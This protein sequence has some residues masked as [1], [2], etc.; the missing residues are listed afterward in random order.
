MELQKKSYNSIIEN[1]LKQ[2]ENI[3]KTEKEIK[4]LKEAY[5]FIEKLWNIQYDKIEKIKFV[6][7]SE[8]PLFGD[9]KHYFYNSNSKFKSFFHK[10]NMESF[11][12]ENYDILDKKEIIQKLNEK[13]F[14]I[15]DLFMFPLNG[16]NTS[17]N[18]RKMKKNRRKELF[19]ISLEFYLKDKLEKI[20]RK[21]SDKIKFFYRYKR[22][23]KII[24]IDF[25]KVLKKKELISRN[26]EIETISNGNMG[27]DNEKL[28][29]IV[30]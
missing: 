25:E 6:M 1:C 7:I 30:S 21:K 5:N 22:L 14:I 20:E 13:G 11:G 24:G 16:K 8:A 17:E 27:I 23:K 19:M 2:L 4:Y 26:T 10:S 28:K 18:F 12:I 15:L 3:G 9:D 29:N